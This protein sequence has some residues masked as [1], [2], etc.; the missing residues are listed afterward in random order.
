MPVRYAE[1]ES[2]GF[3]VTGLE[4]RT[5]V[6]TAEDC[7]PVE[8]AEEDLVAYTATVKDDLGGALPVTFE[9]DLMLDGDTTLVAG[10]PFSAANY[11]PVAFEFSF[12]WTCPAVSPGDH[13][14]TLKWSQQ[15]L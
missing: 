14:V 9:A 10:I 8:V 11:D 3:V 4:R 15:Q 7:V 6:V 13:T 2:T 5:V 12:D 1:G